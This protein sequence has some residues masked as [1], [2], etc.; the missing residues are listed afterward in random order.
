[1]A[2]IYATL[3]IEGHKTFESVPKRIKAK[4]KEVLEQL[5]EGELAVEDETPTNA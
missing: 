5:G 3:I 1:M 2:V 4:V